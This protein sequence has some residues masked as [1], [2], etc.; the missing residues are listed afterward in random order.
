MNRYEVTIEGQTPLLMH[1]DNLAWDT[2]L[3]KWVLDPANKK[4]GIAGD[5]RSPAFRWIGYLY[6]TVNGI[7]P[8]IPSDNIMTMLREGGAKCPTGKGQQTFKAI[9]QSGLIVDQSEWALI[10]PRTGKPYNIKGVDDLVQEPDYIAHEA[11]AANH[12]FELFAKRAKVGSNKHVRVRPRFDH[13]AAAGTITVM[14][15][16]ITADVLQNILTFGG[17]YSG[18]MDWRPSSPK[19]PGV[20]GR[21]TATTKKI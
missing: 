20:F 8:A 18:I 11:W 16:R 3:K 7:S 14:E 9:T 21:F 1:H 17:V 2:V 6:R 10:D 19:S 13:W 12:G 4:N 5:D 15:S